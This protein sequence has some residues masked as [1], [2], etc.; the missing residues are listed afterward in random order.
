MGRTIAPMRVAI[1]TFADVPPQ[2]DD[3]LR[4]AEALGGLGVE[5]D[6]VPWDDAGADWAAYDAVVI[7]STWDYVPRRDEFVA[8]AESVG[9]RLHN[10][11]AIVRWNSDKRYL[12]ELAAAGIPTVETAYV[13]P[14]DERRRST[15]RSSSS[16]RSPPAPAT[17]VASRPPSTPTRSP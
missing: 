17:P 16:P 11:A 2:F 15:A 12:G 6:R 7:R 3:D 5:V 10:S 9:S 14:G 1:A 8:W 4:L 13:G